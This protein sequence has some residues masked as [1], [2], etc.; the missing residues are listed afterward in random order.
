MAWLLDTHVLLWA[1]AE[2]ERLPAEWQDTLADTAD[3]VCF[4]AVNL[5]EIAIKRSLGRLDMPAGFAPFVTEQIG[6][7][8]FRLLPIELAHALRIESLPPQ[9]RDPFDRM[10]V[11]QALVEA[12]PILSRDA[13]LP[14][15]GVDC[16]W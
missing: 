9:H 3:T 15:H 4:S 14:A 10:L 16:L 5:W 13:A 8:G 2:P 11:A 12:V 1:L 6:L 7:N